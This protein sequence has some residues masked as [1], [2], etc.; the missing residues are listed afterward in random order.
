MIMATDYSKYTHTFKKPVEVDGQKLDKIEFDFD[1][2]SGQDMINIEAEIGVREVF[3]QNS[4]EFCA[5]V[6]ARAGDIAAD[7]LAELPLKDFNRITNAAKL[8][9]V[10]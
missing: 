1:K 5:G 7:T 9:L 8:F 4:V 10:M 2:L 3:Q 6:A